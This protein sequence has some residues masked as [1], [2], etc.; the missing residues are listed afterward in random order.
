MSGAD[1]AG[2]PRVSDDVAD[3]VVVDGQAQSYSGNLHE[4]LKLVLVIDSGFTVRRRGTTFR[5]APGQLI[6]LHPDDAHSGTPDDL[7]RARWL[8][9]CVSPSLI[10]EVTASEAVRFGD[11]VISHSGL[12]GRFRSVHSSLHRPS[13]DPG[14]ALRR[15]TEVLEFVS[16]LARHSYRAGADGDG[17]G[18]ARRVPEIAREY[19]RENLA[20]NVTLDELSVVTG[21][22]K[23]RLV[24]VCTAWFGLSPHQL[25]LRLRLDR[26]RVLLRRG[27]GIAEVSHETGFHDQPHLTRVFA[28]AY[29]VTPAV[30]Q[31]TYRGTAWTDLAPR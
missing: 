10:T 6:A 30:Y 2:V 15:E 9:M 18:T 22:S 19:L 21:L 4:E 8:I 28:K 24:R 11:P 31:S 13:E 25:H 3:V 16:A 12:A 7:G 26:A 27:T 14:S 17:T 20:R 29:G 1:Q 23:Y 5:A